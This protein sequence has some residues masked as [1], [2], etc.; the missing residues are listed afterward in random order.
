MEQVS[1]DKRTAEPDEELHKALL[2]FFTAWTDA[3]FPWESC[4]RNEYD[5]AKLIINI[6][7]DRVGEDD[8]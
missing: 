8:E 2:R 6:L 7:R 4:S 3:N 1:K 5:A